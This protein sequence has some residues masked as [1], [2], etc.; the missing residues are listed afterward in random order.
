MQARRARVDRDV[1]FAPWRG[2]GRHFAVTASLRVDTR[3]APTHTA[4]AQ[5]PLPFSRQLLREAI[6]RKDPALDRLAHAVN[7]ELSHARPTNPEEINAILLNLAEGLCC[8]LPAA[9][10]HVQAAARAK[11]GSRMHCQFHVGCL[12]AV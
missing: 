10:V 9:A 4:S 1:N 7:L 2:G 12:P 11:P 5:R 6:K 3:S 8:L